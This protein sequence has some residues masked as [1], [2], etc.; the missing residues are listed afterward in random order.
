M[1]STSRR[2]LVVVL[3]ALAALSITGGAGAQE[4]SDDT[5]SAADG[6]AAAARDTAARDEEARSHFRLAQAQ[7]E[8]GHFAEA[9]EAFERAYALS[10][11]AQ[12]LY[13]LYLA[14]RD[15]GHVVE[16]ADALRNYLARATGIEGEPLL[17]ARLEALDAQIAR[18]ESGAVD[19]TVEPV[20]AVET[21]EPE[22]TS[23]P[24]SSD[25][26]SPAGFALIGVGAAVIVG[27]AVM[28]GVMAADLATV[29]SATPGTPFADVQAAYERTEP[30]SIAGFVSLGVGAAIAVVGVVLLTLPAGSTDTEVALRVGPGAISITGSF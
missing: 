6:D 1:P 22:P 16:A 23:R 7:Y 28:L 13:N 19:E 29:E 21:S 11:R 15:A 3:T 25:D 26:L 24:T 10:G 12:L 18:M 17:R 2:S 9:A 20:D 4:S 14:H 30:L 5:A 27:G 8:V